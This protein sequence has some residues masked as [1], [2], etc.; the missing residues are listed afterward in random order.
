MRI[1]PIAPDLLV[2]ELADRIA[3]DRPDCRLRVA[4]DGPPVADPRRLADSLVDPLRARGRSA[5]H[6]QADDF[7]RPASLRYEQGRT[8]P[9]S[10]YLGWLDEAAVRRELL[11][12]AGPGGSGRI[13]PSLWDATTD[14]ASRA[15]YQ[16][17]PERAVVLLSGAFLLGGSLPFDLVV[18]LDVSAA[19]L[20]RRLPADLRWTLPAFERYTTEVDPVRLADV[21]VRL[22][23]PRRPAVIDDPG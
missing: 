11:D 13:L 1:R 2:S 9:D 12:P 6:I 21:A 10:Y 23:D 5:V 7:L 19:A 16:T 18:H 15:A 17:L 3:G 20:R 14:R 4:V 8:N 22:D